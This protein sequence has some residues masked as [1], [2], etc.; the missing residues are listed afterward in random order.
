MRRQ[1]GVAII[2]AL[3]VVAAAT[4]AV[5]AMMW[6]QSIAVRKVENQNALSQARWLA[7]SS[8]DW[9]RLLLMIDARSSAVDHLGEIW[10]TPLAE[11]KVT[12][13]LTSVA[14][15]SNASRTGNDASEGE[16]AAYV[17]GRIRDAQARLNL[18]GLA[19][20]GAVDEQRYAV[21]QRLVAT[22]GLRSDVAKVVAVE[23]LNSPPG[24]TIEQMTNELIQTHDL[25]RSEAERLRRYVVVLPSPTPVNINTADAEVLSACFTDLPLDAARALVRSREQAWF[26]QISDATARLP[27]TSGQAPPTNVSV[28]SGWFEVEGHVRVG[29]AELGVTA[30]IQRE[31]NG[32]TRVRFFTET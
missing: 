26:N 25:D 27:G 19:K 6:R 5:A 24:A 28:S 32:S 20:D 8:I 4:V 15:G 16:D 17:S 7:R 30:L 3:V 12:D 2:T 1:R 11:T 22:I 21:L 9:S 23:V 13:D 18:N 14:N 31:A 29:R 10:A